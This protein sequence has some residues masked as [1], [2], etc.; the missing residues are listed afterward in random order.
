MYQ[1]AG[2]HK[3]ARPSATNNQLFHKI[4]PYSGYYLSGLESFVG[5]F[6]TSCSY[7]AVID[8]VDNCTNPK[9]HFLSKGAQEVKKKSPIIL[10]LAKKIA[11]KSQL[12]VWDRESS[13]KFDDE[14]ASQLPTKTILFSGRC[15]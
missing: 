14:I 8:A 15:Y 3:K 11:K 9:S 4:F 10:S 5:L 12:V 6:W 2:P 7:K 1:L 13:F